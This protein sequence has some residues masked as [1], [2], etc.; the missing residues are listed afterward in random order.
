MQTICLKNVDFA[1]HKHLVLQNINF[2]F[3]QKDFLAII[4]PNG[5]GKSTLLKLI[6]GLLKPTKGEVINQNQLAYVPQSVNENKIFPISCLEVV[7]MGRLNKNCFGFY[8]K[9]DRKKA[10]EAMDRLGILHLAKENINLLSGGQ[11]QKVAIARALCTQAKIMLLDE[12][13]SNIDTN[14]QIQIY[15]LLKNINE[16]IG[17]IIVS[18]DISVAANFANKIAHVN[19]RLFM[20]TNIQN[21]NKHKFLS[22]FI[23]SNSHVCPV[24]LM[25]NTTK[26]PL[27]MKWHQ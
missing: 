20:H 23:H 16:H 9:L 25:T 26:T 8:T 14:G 21:E 5:G 1:Y 13:T 2:H 19:K 7:L 12:P 17:I 24:E 3:E 10:H 18:H 15:S 11:R 27:I 6:L 22:K 4:G